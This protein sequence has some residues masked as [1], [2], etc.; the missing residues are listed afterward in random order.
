MKIDFKEAW[1]NAKGVPPI[2]CLIGSTRFLDQFFEAGWAYTLKGY[3][4]LSIGVVKTSQVDSDGGHG[5]EMVSQECADMLDE[6]HRR[7]IDLAQE[8]F[9]VNPGGYIGKSTAAEIEYCRQHKKP[10]SYLVAP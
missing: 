7:K 5:A 2:V 1:K 10:I 4:V 9:C 6:L 8:V 3:I